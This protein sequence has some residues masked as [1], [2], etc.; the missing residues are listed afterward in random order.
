M[1]V[2]RPSA[3]EP[4][5]KLAQD[6]KPRNSGTTSPMMPW[7]MSRPEYAPK[8]TLPSSASRIA[9]PYGAEVAPSYTVKISRPG[10]RDR[11]RK[12]F[13]RVADRHVHVGDAP[14]LQLDEHGQP[15][16]GALTAAAGPQ[17]Q[18]VAFPLDTE[19]P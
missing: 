19:A 9:I 5:G 12:V 10:R 1:G 8:I 3:S 17:A 18:D 16:L 11:L 13:Q 6:S 15:E 4:P 2:S 7:P 14:V